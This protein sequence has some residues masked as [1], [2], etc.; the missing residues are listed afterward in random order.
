[1]KGLN[2]AKLGLARAAK[3]LQ[4]SA[5]SV[6]IC[7]YHMLAFGRIRQNKLA[8]FDGD[9]VAL[10]GKLVH[11]HIHECRAYSLFGRIVEDPS[12]QDVFDARDAHPDIVLASAVLSML[13]PR[14]DSAQDVGSAQLA[15][16]FGFD[17]AQ[18]VGSAQ[19]ALASL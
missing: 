6:K 17:S 15:L 11:V 12:A 7:W 8:Y 4:T 14:F 5:A 13:S 2:T 10:R 1:M 3:G 16:A 9:G 19:H 18:D